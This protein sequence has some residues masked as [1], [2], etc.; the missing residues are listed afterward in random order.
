MKLATSIGDL[1]P[2]AATPDEAIR[3][4]KNTGFRY[5]DYNFYEVVKIPIIP[6]WN[7]TGRIRL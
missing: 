4:F 6:S 5:L 3:L 1:F 7:T 2:F